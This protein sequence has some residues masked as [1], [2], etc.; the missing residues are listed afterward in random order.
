MATPS[1]VKLAH[2]TTFLC[3][4]SSLVQEIVIYSPL[5]LILKTNDGE[6]TRRDEISTLRYERSLTVRR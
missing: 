5:A 2:Y 4:L 3:R 6:M 1:A